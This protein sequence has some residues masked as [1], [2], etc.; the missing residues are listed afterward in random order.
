[1]FAVVSGVVDGDWTPVHEFCE[2]NGVPCVF[3]MADA[4]PDRAIDAG[5]YSLYFSKGVG[6]EAATLAQS[7]EERA[8]QQ[9]Q[10]VLQVSRCGSAGERAAVQLT[11]D[12]ARRFVVA[13]RC[14]A[15]GQPLTAEV[16]R[17]WI[18]DATPTAVV[19]WL[20]ER[21]LGGLQSLADE[22]SGPLRARG[23]LRVR[24][25]RRRRHRVRSEGP[26]ERERI[27]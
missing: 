17:Q 2:K 19:A 9:P 1:M 13:S 3:P 22:P 25:A 20:A 4:P 21:D 7:L 5:F 10:R 18:E 23:P 12:A 27:S 24:H 14:A 26:C 15:P 16:W 11:S 6:L 8:S